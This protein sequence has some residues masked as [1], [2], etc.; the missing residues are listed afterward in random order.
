[1]LRG[2]L[3][4]AGIN[5]VAC[6]RTTPRTTPQPWRYQLMPLLE[7]LT[8]LNCSLFPQGCLSEQGRE[9]EGSAGAV[10]PAS[11][12]RSARQNCSC[13]SALWDLFSS[14]C[15]I[16][17]WWEFGLLYIFVVLK[18]QGSLAKALHVFSF[19]FSEF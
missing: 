17:F 18:C 15:F 10:K 6:P 8:P 7:V 1:M 11:V 3:L 13:F 4:W 16:F 2:H 9:K 19:F 12:V 5:M 14:L